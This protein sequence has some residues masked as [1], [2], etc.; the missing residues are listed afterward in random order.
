MPKYA[1][2]LA[3][4]VWIVAGAATARA[5]EPG[6]AV[7]TFSYGSTTVTLAHATETKVE[8]LFDSS[9]QDTLVVLSDE[10]LGATAAGDDVALSLR[11][12]TG[13]ITALALRIDGSRL[14]NV[15]V[16]HKGLSGKASLPGAWFQ[17]AASKPG[18]GTLKLAGREFD[19]TRYACSVEFA[20]APAA[21]PAVAPS[22]QRAPTLAPKAAPA[23]TSSIEKKPATALLVA[24]FMQK[25]EHQALE[26]IKLGADPNGRDQY[27][28]PMLNWA[29]MMCMPRA[30]QALVE[31]KASLSYERAPGMTIMTEAG[32]CPEAARIL[33]AAGAK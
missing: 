17:Y 16:F 28:V 18:I 9:R 32:A 4:A 12:R 22:A 14:V 24:A 2:P 30:V 8:G 25:D 29:I 20:A 10:A 23:T 13:E 19:G 15:A 7:G 33:R 1:T 6:Q 27:G 26:L 5:A 3:L 11:A 31:R 21:K